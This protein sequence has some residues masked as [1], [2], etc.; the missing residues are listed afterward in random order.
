MQDR[1]FLLAL[2]RWP[3][4]MVLWLGLA[5]G[6]AT[7]AAA[8]VRDTTA[9]RRDTTVAPADTT[10]APPPP[11]FVT[12]S[13]T[14]AQRRAAGTWYWDRAAL[15]TS[16]AVSL[17]DLIASIP[18]ALTLRAGSFLQPEVASVFGGTAPR[19]EVELDGYILDPLT[20]STLDLSNIE[21][22]PWSEVLVERRLDVLRIRL[23]SAAAEDA[24]PYSRVEAGVGQPDTNLFRGIFL[25]PRVLVGPFGFSLDRVDTDGSNGRQAADNFNAW[26]KWGWIRE[27][28]GL[29][30][31]LR[32]TNLNREPESPWP[33]TQR[34]QDL[35]LRGRLRFAP[36]L[37]AEGFVGHSLV[38]G[39]DFDLDPV[40]SIPPRDIERTSLQAGARARFALPNIWFEGT[41][42][43]RDQIA[44]PRL[45]LDLAA[46]VGRHG[47]GAVEAQLTQAHW[48]QVPSTL[49]INMRAE[50][51][52]FFGVTPFA[53]WMTGK[54]AA[55]L[56]D[57]TTALGALI[58]D[59]S[60]YRLGVDADARGFAASGALVHMETDSVPAFRLPFDSAAL[61]FPGGS[62]TGIEVSARAPLF[63]NWLAATGSLLRW[64]SGTRWAYLPEQVA[65]GAIELRA[66]PLASRNVEFIGRLEAL[67]R[68]SMLA[69]DPA[70]ITTLRSLGA[71]TLIN[72]YF[73]IRIIDVRIF[74]RSDDMTGNE[75]EDL[76]GHLVRGPRLMYGVQWQFWN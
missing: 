38:E 33:G 59:R 26:L 60:G 41:V 48:R 30:L 45:Q 34:R 31:E 62:V 14:W 52:P 43:T 17:L 1:S 13:R 54:R 65:R 50:A 55:P 25:A 10:P 39:A 68:G 18:G 53:E 57:D 37:T 75:V 64:N 67:H 44:L 27:A 23:R 42:R 28:G 6:W 47:T 66:S 19:L 72:G 16:G 11:P 32:R 73:Q 2:G 51:G 46:G 4:S 40:D 71:R 8:Q 63:V 5:C 70:D 22:N 3:G 74:I 69:P 49:A 15:A 9:V 76:P 20:A 36:A 58:D 12:L 61:Q 24:R 29:Q 21:L 7:P 56:Y 35:I